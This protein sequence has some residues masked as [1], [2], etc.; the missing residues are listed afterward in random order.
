MDAVSALLRAAIRIADASAAIVA[1]D[2]DHRPVAFTGCSQGAAANA[3]SD[4]TGAYID[5]RTPVTPMTLVLLEPSRAT[6]G[7]A[8]LMALANELG[9]AVLES[10]ARLR[11]RAGRPGR[12]HRD[13]GR[14]GGRVSLRPHRAK[15]SRDSRASTAR[16]SGSSATRRANCPGSPK[17][18]CTWNARP[19]T[20]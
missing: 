14:S 8:A 2:D 16:S 4:G 19:W 20:T 5:C 15:K 17:T 6:A 18:S 3:L 9:H 1:Y 13:A 12:E 7:D 11:R 10:A